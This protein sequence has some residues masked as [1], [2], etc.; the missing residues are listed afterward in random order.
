MNQYFLQSIFW[1]TR[2]QVMLPTTIKMILT[3]EK[4]GMEFNLSQ[5]G[6]IND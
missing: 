5:F 2:Y 6:I 4:L 3:F 1:N